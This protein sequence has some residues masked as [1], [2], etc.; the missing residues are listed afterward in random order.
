M[1]TYMKIAVLLI[2]S[3]IL[4]SF[5][6]SCENHWIRGATDYMFCDECGKAYARCIC[7]DDPPDD[8][9][10]AL[11]HITANYTGTRTIYTFTL[12][13]SL[14][15]DLT[16]RAFFDD[17]S[18]RKLG[19]SEYVL[20]GTLA[21]GARTI[22]VH[23][24]GK[25][26]TF[27]VTVSTVTVTGITA[28]YNQGSTIV[29]PN[30]PLDNLKTGLTVTAAYSNG[31]TATVSDYILTGDLTVGTRTITAN[32]GG[33]TAEFVV[34]VSPMTLYS[35]AVTVTFPATGETPVTAASSEDAGYTTSAVTWTRADGA[36]MDAV[37]QGGTQ[38]RAEVTLAANAGYVF[39]P[40][41][42]FTAEINGLTASPS[43]NT[44]S[45]VT[46]SYTFDATSAAA[47]TGISVQ[48]Q[49][50]LSYTHG[51]ALDL[52][53]IV[54][55]ITY[56]D[57]S[58]KDAPFAAFAANGI[59]AS[60][61]NGTALSH[62]THNGQ[63]ITIALGAT[64]T[65]A[66]NNLAV[67]QAV[68]SA[69]IQPTAGGI[70]YGAALSA[71]SLTGGS[72]GGK[73]AWQTP[74]TIPTVTNSGY[75]VTFTPDDTANYN[76]TNVT[77]VFT[78][79]ITVAQAVPSALIQPTA[80]GIT[81][82]AA[83]SE[84]SLT[85][86][87]TGGKWAWQ[88]PSTIPTVTNSGYQVTFTPDDTAN[89]NWT[90]VTFEFTIPITV[91][92]APIASAAVNITA[93]VKDTGATNASVTDTN[94]TAVTVWKNPAG[95]THTG[96]FAADTVYTAEVTLTAKTNYTFPLDFSVTSTPTL[97]ITNL[98]ITNSAPGINANSVVLAYTFPKTGPVTG[99]AEG[100]K[101]TYDIMTDGAPD[102][103]DIETG[104]I[105]SRSAKGSQEFSVSQAE[106]PK[107]IWYLD[108]E[109]YEKHSITVTLNPADTDYNFNYDR[110]GK[111]FLTV[112]AQDAGGT[113]HSKTVWFEVVDM[114]TLTVNDQT[115][116]IKA[117]E[118]IKDGGNDI[119]YII[120][121]TENISIPGFDGSN[122]FGNL[123]GIEVTITGSGTLS[124][125]AADNSASVLRIGANQT[126]IVGEIG[127]QE[128]PTLRRSVGAFSRSVVR[129]DN[130]GIFE[131]RSGTI[132]GNYAS[133]ASSGGVHVTGTGSTFIMNGGEISGNTAVVGG[134]QVDDGG[135]FIM[136]AG[137]I[138]GNTG[139]NVGGVRVRETGV[140]IMNGGIISDN[141][142]SSTSTGATLAG[143]VLALNG[144]TFR[145][146]G[147]TIYGSV[148]EGAPS[149]YA[150]IVSVSGTNA[151]A[152]LNIEN[153]TAIE[154]GRFIGD[155]R[156]IDEN[157]KGEGDLIPTDS[158]IT[159]NNG[160]LE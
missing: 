6:F 3:L 139:E 144:G 69:L 151:K 103:D 21:V 49:P 11:T 43:D 27:N 121:V 63:S 148:A 41:P 52:S 61:T 40:A 137:V 22:T 19:S 158:T 84:S 92:P 4:F 38:Y 14:K 140:F 160:M 98:E 36:A 66:T 55:R 145:M 54:V 83:L 107:V 133:T 50:R 5:F 9:P 146:S 17:G 109:E 78:I 16:V 149:E 101:I 93:P 18:E 153:S 57:G 89:Y 114:S 102:D 1:K 76:W 128:G 112:F 150:N 118:E 44:G 110:Q 82:G 116:F 67:A 26:T 147:G 156:F 53:T 72:T 138:S 59:S 117:I 51:D 97:E 129:V 88:T 70:T 105:L 64:H 142:S 135:I 56:G 20:T 60:L 95:G 58:T 37:F 32:Y 125:D 100:F 10:A 85:G 77:T 154:Y 87:S 68:P 119:A 31:T 46:A 65:T 29:Y 2:F 106:F 123:T 12:R 126:I 132:T 28:D 152:A 33:Q 115:G 120:N 75:Q 45:Q 94:I 131:L 71:S 127:S 13:D 159:V 143:G 74:S 136:N 122:T 91:S 111:H 25:T 134:V 124:V 141:T 86:D 99:N 34:E 108:D 96:A 15:D 23:Y 73:W 157:W 104:V 155:G 47:V 39:A 62:S 42:S 8:P 113:L 30:T 24:G 7:V 90:G 35:A 81:Y 130:G 80:D 48:T 79:P